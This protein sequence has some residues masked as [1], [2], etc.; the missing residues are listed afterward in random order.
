LTSKNLND[1]IF[2]GLNDLISTASTSFLNV[3]DSLKSSQ[4]TYFAKDFHSP[5]FKIVPFITYRESQIGVVSFSKI[6]FNKTR[7]QALLY[8]E[9]WYGGKCGMGE[10]LVLANEDLRWKIKRKFQVWIA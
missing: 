3:Y 7:D 10:I 8:Y 5:A 1:S 6:V 9:F 4:K 2:S